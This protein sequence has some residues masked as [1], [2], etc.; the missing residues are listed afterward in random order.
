[1]KEKW[2]NLGFEL[3][4]KNQVGILLLAGG[5]VCSVLYSMVIFTI[6]YVGYKT[7]NYISKRNV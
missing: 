3:Y 6:N 5:Q 4:A 7:W 2:T 1:M